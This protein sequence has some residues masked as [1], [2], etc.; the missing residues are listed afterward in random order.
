MASGDDPPRKLF[1]S[2]FC[3]KKL[4]VTPNIARQ[5]DKGEGPSVPSILPTPPPPKSQQQFPPSE[6]GQGQLDPPAVVPLPLPGYFPPPSMSPH[7]PSLHQA[8]ADPFYPYYPPPSSQV[9]GPSTSPHPPYPYPYYY[10]YPM[11]PEHGGSSRPADVG[12]GDHAT[13]ADKR[14]YIEPEGDK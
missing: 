14:Q 7:F 8:H 5:P 13:A 10:P 11:Q 3:R 2:K 6:Q 12:V 4:S 1:A 9:A